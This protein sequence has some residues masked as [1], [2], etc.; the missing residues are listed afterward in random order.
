MSR[1]DLKAALAEVE[2]I[3]KI[4]IIRE[5]EINKKET[6]IEEKEIKNNLKINRLEDTVDILR[7]EKLKLKKNLEEATVTMHEKNDEIRRLKREI[8]LKSKINK[9]K[10]ENGNDS[11]NHRDDSSIERKKDSEVEIPK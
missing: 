7:K 8:I 9:N 5:N 4:L 11:S 3:R 2:K 1:A 6:E 10:I